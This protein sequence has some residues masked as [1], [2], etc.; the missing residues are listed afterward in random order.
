MLRVKPSTISLTH[1]EL[2][3]FE[4]RLSHTQADSFN[5]EQTADDEDELSAAERDDGDLHLSSESAPSHED[6]DLTR[7]QDA[8][9]TAAFGVN[10]SPLGS[11]RRSVSIHHRTIPGEH[12]GIAVEAAAQSDTPQGLRGGSEGSLNEP[13]VFE[14]PLRG[15]IPSPFSPA[16]RATH[17]ETEQPNDQL[18]SGRDDF[19][20]HGDDLPSYDGGTGSGGPVVGDGRQIQPRIEHTMPPSYNAV[21]TICRRDRGGV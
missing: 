14:L 17:V 20:A 1:V 3:D 4:R 12:G 10:L 16:P 6:L 13:P 8:G 18:Q 15:A 11:M 9:S 19:L 5:L 21:A 7:T 2:K